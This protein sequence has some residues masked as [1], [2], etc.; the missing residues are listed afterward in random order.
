[1]LERIIKTKEGEA[2]QLLSL[3]DERTARMSAYFSVDTALPSGIFLSL[4]SLWL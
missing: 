4:M 2:V 3:L 1:M